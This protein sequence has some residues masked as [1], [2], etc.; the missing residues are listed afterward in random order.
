MP[1]KL[2]SDELVVE[3]PPVTIRRALIR[4]L[5]ADGKLPAGDDLELI[6]RTAVEDVIIAWSVNIG[7]TRSAINEYVPRKAT[8]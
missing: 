4:R 7:L 1:R 5:Q 6:V 2:A 3:L 8:K